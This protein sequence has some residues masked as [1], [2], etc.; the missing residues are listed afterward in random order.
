[1]QQAQHII[2]TIPYV[3][4][5]KMPKHSHNITIKDYSH[6]NHKYQL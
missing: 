6:G 1:M 5:L 4:N 3:S 2:T